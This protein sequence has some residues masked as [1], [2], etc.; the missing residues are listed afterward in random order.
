VT[1][2]SDAGSA[3]SKLKPR[4]ANQDMCNRVNLDVFGTPITTTSALPT[5]T[6]SAASEKM[7]RS[8]ASA[9]SPVAIAF[10]LA[11]FGQPF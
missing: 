11:I 2:T 6:S 4:N 3:K 5:A 8:R 7:I 10:I 9:N 1:L